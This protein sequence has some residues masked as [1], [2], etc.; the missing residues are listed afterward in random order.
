MTADTVST[1][2]NYFQPPADGSKPWFTVDFNP[3]T[4]ERDSNFKMDKITLEIENVRG[5]EDEYDIDSSGFRFLKS[6]SGFTNFDDEA[7]I[8]DSYFKESAEIIKRIT[9]ARRVVL[10]DH[11]IRRNRPGVLE[12]SEQTRGPVSTVHVDQ[13]PE[14]AAK[15]VHRH[16]PEHIASDL[17]KYRFQIIN[18]WRPINHM[19]L[20]FPLALCDY[21][22]VSRENDL[23]P[24]I[25]KSPKGD[26][27][28]FSVKYSPRHRWK[29]LRGMRTDEI[30]LI[31][32]FDSR[33]DGKTAIFTPHSAF[34]DPTTPKD[35]PLRESIELRALVL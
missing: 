5:H 22:T 21:R 35:A 20:D 29:Y 23:I 24:T 19:A 33:M 31:K 18:L 15:R 27:E 13:T 16:T 28:T 3:K 7:V 32:C 10:F 12:T 30:V 25:L 11:T 17:L 34:V 26:G 6:P 1:T 8:K 9:S 4:G 2:L 14:S